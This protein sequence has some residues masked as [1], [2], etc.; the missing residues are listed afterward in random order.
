ML[1][2]STGLFSFQFSSMDG[3]NSM[4]EN[5]P[6]FIRNHPL[7]LRKWNPDVDLLKEDVWNVS[8]WVKLHGVPVTVFSED[9]L[10]AV[11]MKLGTLLMLDSYTSHMCLQSW[12]MSSYARVMIELWTD[13]ELKHNIK[14]AM[15]KIMEGGGEECPKNTGLGMAKNLKKPSQTSRGVLVCPKVG[16]KP[17]K[18]HRP[19]PKKPTASPSGNKKKGVARTNEV[20]N[21]NPFDVL[22]SVDNDVELGTNGG[23]TNLVN[24]GANSSGSSYMNV[25]NSST[26]NTPIIDKIKKFEDLLIDGQAILVDEVGNPLQKV[27]CPGDYDSEDEVASVDNDTA[28]SLASKRVG[29]GTQSLL[30]QLRDS[31]GNG[32]HDE[33]HTMM[34]CMKAM[35]FLK[36]FKLYAIIQISVFEVARRNKFMFLLSSH[37]VYLPLRK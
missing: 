20:S 26:S 6:W 28:R 18:E 33:H 19:V 32:D 31:Y 1:N 13:M 9:G 17:H 36:R 35:N 24:N 37:F 16:F 5:G 7:I 3:L 4:L 11:A 30:E 22:N 27:E 8:V 25:E 15:P 10:S 14:V 21:S 2:S 12:G 29:F 23:T 34:I